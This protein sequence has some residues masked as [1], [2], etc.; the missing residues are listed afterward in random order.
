MK[1][2]N[3]Y[4]RNKKARFVIRIFA[5]AGY[6]VF[7]I[8]WWAAYG[9][10]TLLYHLTCDVIETLFIMIEGLAA[11]RYKLQQLHKHL[12]YFEMLILLIGSIAV[13][14]IM[15]SLLWMIAL[16]VPTGY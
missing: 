16:I 4:V 11:A 7:G 6:A 3:S 5:A 10:I 1:T 9:L 15:T 14:T 13:M 8:V 2:L 12:S